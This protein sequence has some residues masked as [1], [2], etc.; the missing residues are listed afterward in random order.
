MK[1]KTAWKRLSASVYENNNGDIIHTL[2]TIKHNG[3]IITIC[4]KELLELHQQCCRIM[5]FNEKRSL[6]L[7]CEKLST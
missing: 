5:G 4:S 7:M 2:G 1:L 3:H 6:M